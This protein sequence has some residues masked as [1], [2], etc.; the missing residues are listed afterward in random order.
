MNK[1]EILERLERI[2]DSRDTDFMN[3]YAIE[4]IVKDIQE[5]R[6]NVSKGLKI[7]VN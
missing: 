1:Y 6:M 2:V 3:R 7:G 4:G 5:L